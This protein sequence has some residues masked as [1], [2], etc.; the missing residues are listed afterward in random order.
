MPKPLPYVAHPARA[1]GRTTR[2]R[3][4]SRE[5]HH[6]KP[7]RPKARR[8][9]LVGIAIQARARTMRVRGTLAHFPN[10]FVD[11]PAHRP[12]L[13]SASCPTERLDNES[14]FIRRQTPR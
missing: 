12:V 4:S 10:V 3:Q 14:V 11:C 6:T 5:R 13:G 7:C 1:L 8:P 2:P 9:C